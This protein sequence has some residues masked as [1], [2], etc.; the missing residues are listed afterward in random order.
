LSLTH[1]HDWAAIEKACQVAHGHASF[2][3][4]TI[5]ALIDRQAPSQQR[6]EFM[7]QHAIIRQLSEYDQFV[8][9]AFQ[10]EA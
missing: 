4:R 10:K 3:L 8:H 9:E 2:R 6:F 5:R 7:A 1:R